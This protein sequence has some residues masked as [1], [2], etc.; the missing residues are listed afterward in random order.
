M[1]HYGQS[2][3]TVLEDLL[4]RYPDSPLLVSYA[5][6][7]L[8]KNRLL[9]PVE[10]RSRVTS[11]GANYATL[12]DEDPDFRSAEIIR[13][14][15]VGSSRSDLLERRALG[16]YP[17]PVHTLEVYG[18]AVYTVLELPFPP[19]YEA[20]RRMLEAAWRATRAAEPAA[21][22]DFDVWLVDR[23]LV[24]VSESCP[25]LP[26]PFR[27]DGEAARFHLHVTPADPDDL[28]AQ[29]REIGFANLDFEFH[30]RGGVVEGRCVAVAALPAYPV[31]GVRTGQSAR[32][33][34]P[35]SALAD[36]WRYETVWE[37]EFPVGEAP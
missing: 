21:R 11:R 9:L 14:H 10:A 20:H 32:A 30:E 7:E 26:H 36:D 25:L 18:A 24:Y 29:R 8:P 13:L 2:L 22:S 34:A 19:G 6:S 37:V 23:A 35:G 31:A 17:E 16:G 15:I 4:D 3:R 27:A 28:P 1:D 33:P 12:L 5:F